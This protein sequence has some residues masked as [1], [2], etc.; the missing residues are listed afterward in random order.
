[1]KSIVNNY[2]RHKGS[3]LVM[4]MLATA[5]ISATIMYS[6][7]G[8]KQDTH[9]SYR[10]VEEV[11]AR[12]MAEGAINRA[13]GDVLSQIAATNFLGGAF[14]TVE[15]K[16]AMIDQ[17]FDVANKR[18]PAGATT[19]DF[20]SDSIKSKSRWD[21]TTDTAL[22]LPGVNDWGVGTGAPL[23]EVRVYV[24]RSHID[25]IGNVATNSVGS[26]S[27]TLTAAVKVG[28]DVVNATSIVSRTYQHQLTFPR[29]FDFLMLGNQISDCSMCHLKIWGDIGQINPQD[30]FEMHIPY[31]SSRFNRLSMYGNMFLNG[32]FMRNAQSADGATASF[33]ERMLMNGGTGD[34]FIY[35]LNGGT[36]ATQW[37]SSN[38][39][40]SNP[41]RSIDTLSTPLPKVWPSVKANL[42]NW[43]EPRATASAAADGSEIRVNPYDNNIQREFK[44]W[45]ASNNNTFGSV[46]IGYSPTDTAVPRNA[47][48]A[49]IYN[50]AIDRVP[51]STAQRSTAGVLTYNGGLHPADDLDGDSIPNIFDCD[52]DGDG[53]PEQPRQSY[54]QY[55]SGYT[56]ARIN[57]GWE[58]V[59]AADVAKLVYDTNTGRNEWRVGRTWSSTTAPT[60]AGP[61]WIRNTTTPTYQ[62][63]NQNLM[64]TNTSW[65][66][67]RDT[68]TSTNFRWTA[69]VT[70][71]ATSMTNLI[72][73]TFASTSGATPGTV[74][75]VFPSGG[76]DGSGNPTYT[77]GDGRNR[78]LFIIG[79]KKNPIYAKGHVVVR[80]DVLIAGYMTNPT[81]FKGATLVTHRNIYLPIDLRYL[82]PPDWESSAKTGDQF[83]LVAGG[84][85]LIGNIIHNTT[86]KSD[87]M[88][89]VWGNMIN[90]NDVNM[91]SYNWGRDGSNSGTKQCNHQINPV[92]LPD[93]AE[94]GYWSNGEWK[95]QNAG[96]TV[97]DTFNS[98]GMQIGGGLVTS[99]T[100]FN[101]ARKHLHFNYAS[102][103]NAAAKTSWYK[104]YYISTPGL[105]PLGADLI[106]TFPSN[107]TA[108]SDGNYYAKW[109]GANLWMTTNDFKFFVLNPMNGSNYVNNIGAENKVNWIKNVESVLYADFG[110]IGGNISTSGLDADG[111]GNF[112]EFKG[113]IIGRD[114]QILAALQANPY[115][116]GTLETKFTN[117]VGGLYYDKR[118]KGAINPL[119]FPF[120]EEFVGGEM[121]Q[122]GVPPVVN[123]SRDNWVPWRMTQD[124]K[125]AFE[126]AQH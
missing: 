35:C 21:F 2:K 39:G 75:G 19:I 27:G 83:G 96:N 49:T 108:D 111:K 57:P 30:P 37:A 121:A 24:S 70:G 7:S 62:V 29:L 10:A 87:L 45:N 26:Y 34:S 31:N 92:Y 126:D 88:E 104:S 54:T 106:A 20:D 119:G 86:G 46:W 122:S 44:S 73:N 25:G 38:G 12:Y 76:V 66:Y 14:E 78:S 67:S 64:A 90:I 9:A 112:L 3:A 5:V 22:D 89:F 109:T 103:S 42:V 23:G 98:Q 47:G 77:L 116:N 101:S 51:V 65:L 100:G 117:K 40:G 115:D 18:L 1:M 82:N 81:G 120:T 58:L 74:R 43:F 11:Q 114:I 48:L 55:L 107:T 17:R 118:L 36:L 60:S 102:N 52:I 4:V 97:A 113:T 69:Q 32:P 99:G 71:I 79:S 28:N 8:A 94:G 13:K 105:L 95:Q 33:Q 16:Y 125:D 84:N 123:G 56:P 53:T 15:E 110:V 41:F 50:K 72:N 91:Q 124:Y 80:G 85:I 93:G 63:A 6:V 68:P 61:R 59:P